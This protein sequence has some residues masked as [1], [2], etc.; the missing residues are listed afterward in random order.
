MNK[1]SLQFLFVSGI[2]FSCLSGCNSNQQKEAENISEEKN[3]ET[4]ER[5]SQF[6]TLEIVLNSNDKMQF[7][8]DEIIVWEDQTIILTLNHTGTMSKK[9]MGHNFVL[10][11]NSISIAGYAK[12]AMRA[13]ANDYIPDGEKHT[14]AYTDLIGGGES[15]T[16][17]FESPKAGSY[18]FVCSFPGHYSIMKGKFIVK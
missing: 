1:W 18:D 7:D 13:E 12:L 15:T 11:D 5:F 14:L 3:I 6:D 16:I 4:E 2:F 17:I 9:S 10:I 8:K